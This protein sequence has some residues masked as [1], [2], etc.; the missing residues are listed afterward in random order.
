MAVHTE[1]SKA[2]IKEILKKY[3]L[4]ELVSYEGI[5]EGIENTNYLIVTE[6]DKFIITIF[7]KRVDLSQIPFYFEIM[8]NSHSHGI[9]CPIPIKDK[10][11]EFV[12][13]IKKKKM[14]V[15]IF[16]EGQSKKEWTNNDCFQ[17]GEKLAKFHLANKE[18]KIVAT[19][20]FGLN[21]WKKTLK[22]CSKYLESV[23]PN[24]YKII[25]REIGFVS[26][27]WPKK[28]P[29]GIIHADLF[30][31]NVFF[32]KKNISGFLDFYFSC[33]DFLSYDLAITVNAWCFYKQKFIQSFFY[34]LLSG[35]ESIRK[36]EREEI[37][38]FNILLRG[39]AL[40]FLF[41]RIYDSVN[42]KKSKLLK[43]KDPLEFYDILNFHINN[44]SL[45]DYFE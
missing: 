27:N 40:R 21:Y 16:L 18:N 17:V 23:I 43:P 26:S 4:G 2:N 41:T 10:Y 36:L 9:D 20:N 44:K 13:V 8:I 3:E 24:S 22:K 45:D 15:F 29:S 42:C 5:Q 38:N 6:K 1:L 12:N 30:P 14:A 34:N 19:N 33:F 37:K 28:L 25:H 31:D 7:E 11:G 35:Y 32:K 39:A